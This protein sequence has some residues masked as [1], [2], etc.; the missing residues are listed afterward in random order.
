[1]TSYTRVGGVSALIS[2]AAFGVSGAVVSPLLDVGWSSASAVLARL[3]IGA[4][5][6][7]PWVWSSMAGHWVH[8][9]HYL[10]QMLT[11]GIIG[12]AGSQLCYFYA[13]RT[14][15]VAVALLIEYLAPVLVLLWLRVVH[16]TPLARLTLVGAAVAVAGTALVLQMPAGTHLDPVGTAWAL[17]AA[18]GLATYFLVADASAPASS[19]AEVPVLPPVALAGGG[20]VVGSVVL[21][22]S[23][24]S[25]IL[26]WSA[27]LDAVHYRDI[28][29]PWWFPV[30]VLGVVTAALAYLS[31]VLAVRWLGS[32]IASFL[33]LSEILVAA[34]VSSVLLGQTFTVWQ[35]VGAVVVITGILIIRHPGNATPGSAGPVSTGDHM[36][37][38]VQTLQ[39]DS[40]NMPPFSARRVPGCA[41]DNGGPPRRT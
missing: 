10:R 37:S 31:G 34:A 16:K 23:S 3:S 32:K 27:P 20:L 18:L 7:A 13:I 39:R 24:A 8:W 35:M 14:I 15:P 12:V 26:P 21:I 22:L 41:Q 1:M 36:D 40:P 29:V 6:L 4:I 33:A 11:Y 17:G 25:G 28:M 5:V 38:P 9:R 19:D 2:A 30:L